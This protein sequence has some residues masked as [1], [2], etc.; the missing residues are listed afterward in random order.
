[1]REPGRQDVLPPGPVSQCSLTPRLRS[2]L[3]PCAG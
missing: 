1:M 2:R 3:S